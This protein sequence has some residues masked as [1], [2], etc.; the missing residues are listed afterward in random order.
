MCCRSVTGCFLFVDFSRVHVVDRRRDQFCTLQH[1]TC[2]SI[3]YI[4]SN[5]C[6]DKGRSGSYRRRNTKVCTVDM[7]SL[8]N[9]FTMYRYKRVKKNGYVQLVTNKGPLNVELYAADVPK[10]CENFILLCKK[11]YYDNTIFHRLIKNFMVSST[12]V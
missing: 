4:D 8:I 5:A 12:N 10:T 3:V 11:G 6:R 1:R 9:S 7:S 2:S